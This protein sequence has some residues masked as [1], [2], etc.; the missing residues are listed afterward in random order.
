VRHGQCGRTMHGPQASLSVSMGDREMS[1]NR[2]YSFF[3]FLKMLIRAK[4]CLI[5]N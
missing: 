1:E 4:S 5:Y 3:I 2:I